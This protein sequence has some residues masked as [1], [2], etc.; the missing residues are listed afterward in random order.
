MFIRSFTVGFVG[1]LQMLVS[2][3]QRYGVEFVGLAEC[4]AGSARPEA[5][6][7]SGNCERF[8]ASSLEI[9]PIAYSF[10]WPPG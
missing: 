1:A 10:E 5:Q 8:E 3:G 9:A 6:Q 4:A 2:R 7:L